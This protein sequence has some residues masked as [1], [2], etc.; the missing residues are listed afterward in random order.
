MF[1]LKTDL[2]Q[3]K[4][5][6]VS[7][8][9]FPNAFDSVTVSLLKAAEEAGT[10]ETTLND[11][12]E[13]VE[14]EAEFVDKIRLALVYPVLIS[15]VFLGVLLVILVVVVPKI[16]TVF[17]RL[18]VDLP[19]PTRILISVSGL[20]LNHTLAFVGGLVVGIVGIYLLLKFNKQ[21]VFN[22]LFSLPLVSHLV[23]TIDLTR[24]TRTLHLLLSSGIPIDNAL[25][26][27]KDVVLRSSTSKVIIKSREMVL[28]GKKLAD[29]LRTDPHVIPGIMLRLVEAGEKSGSLEKSMKDISVHLDYQVSNLLKTLTSVMEPVMLL[30]VGL[31]V[32]GMMLAIIAP[33]YGL[34]GQVN[35]R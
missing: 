10:L 4:H 5:L 25:L 3:G 7:F 8:S 14:K 18:R 16:A 12:R 31:S 1:F 19:L 27:C 24:F 34:I 33:I 2:V 30:L 17:S 21:R 6:Y 11:L 29:G 32:G 26:L 22:V 35:M 13:H 9:A 28:S 23:K 20:L 15:I